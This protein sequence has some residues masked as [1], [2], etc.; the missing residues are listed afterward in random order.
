[1]QSLVVGGLAPGRQRAPQPIAEN[2]RLAMQFQ[3]AQHLAVQ[4][5]QAIQQRAQAV[6]LGVHTLQELVAQL[7]ILFGATQ[8][9]LK[10]RLHGA[11]GPAQLVDQVGQQATP[12]IL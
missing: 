9:G 1:M 8:Q 3:R 12:G 10:P 7:R 6:D 4:V 5:G 2:D 11:Q